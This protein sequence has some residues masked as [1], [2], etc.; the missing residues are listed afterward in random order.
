MVR[1]FGLVAA[2]RQPGQQL[3]TAVTQTNRG[4]IR[5]GHARDGARSPGLKVLKDNDLWLDLQSFL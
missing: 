2:V 3:A 5:I 4:T 1:A